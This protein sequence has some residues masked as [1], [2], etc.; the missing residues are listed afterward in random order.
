MGSQT[1]VSAV[2]Q[3]GK[4]IIQMSGQRNAVGSVAMLLGSLDGVTHLP[5]MCDVAGLIWR[6]CTEP[7]DF[8]SAQAN[9][10][11]LCLIKAMQLLKYH[12][13]VAPCF[14]CGPR[15]LIK[16]SVRPAAETPYPPSNAST[17]HTALRAT[18]SHPS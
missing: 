18:T 9:D 1:R 14:S 15:L 11:I 6:R 4:A 17:Q 3:G 10:K 8:R 13:R 16:G 7:Q 12:S 2:C 5:S